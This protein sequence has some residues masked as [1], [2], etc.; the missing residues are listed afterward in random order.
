MLPAAN[1]HPCSDITNDPNRPDDP[2]YILRLLAKVI[3]LSLETVKIVAGLP[4]L[5]IDEAE[6]VVDA[7]GVS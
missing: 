6:P 2:Q 1:T 5:G 7:S 3:S 4:A